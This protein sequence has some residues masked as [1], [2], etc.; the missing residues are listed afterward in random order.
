MNINSRLKAQGLQQQIRLRKATER[1]VLVKVNYG[2]HLSTCTSSILKNEHQTELHTDEQ[3]QIKTKS[4]EQIRL[5][6]ATERDV[7]VYRRESVAGH[8]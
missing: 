5:R 4:M 1:D 6:K 8:G 2:S 7:F 3:H